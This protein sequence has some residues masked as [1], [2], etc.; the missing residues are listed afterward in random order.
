MGLNI[1][2]PKEVTFSQNN[3]YWVW[4]R[5]W[6]SF[7]L[8][9][10]W[11]WTNHIGLG[12]F[13]CDPGIIRCWVEAAFD[14]STQGQRGLWSHCTVGPVPRSSTLDYITLLCACTWSRIWGAGLPWLLPAPGSMLSPTQGWQSAGVEGKYELLLL[15]HLMLLSCAQILIRSNRDFHGSLSIALNGP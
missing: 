4:N 8:F 2:L 3:L 10:K 9:T 5:N 1:F 13:W 12:G 15:S 6:F 11:K 14:T 7:L